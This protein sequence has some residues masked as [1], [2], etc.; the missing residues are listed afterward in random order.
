MTIITITITIIITI[1]MTII[2]IIMTI[3]MTTTMTIMTINYGLT[4][5]LRNV[6]RLDGPVGARED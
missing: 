6:S 5:L 2:T 4:Q 3:I 1:I